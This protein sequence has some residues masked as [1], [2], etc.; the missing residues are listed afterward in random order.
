MIQPLTN[1]NMPFYCLNSNNWPIW[2]STFQ[3][4]S[5]LDF[6]NWILAT[7]LEIGRFLDELGDFWIFQF[8]P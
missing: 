4:G 6:G 8:P 5:F 1:L 2:H 7:G 3:V